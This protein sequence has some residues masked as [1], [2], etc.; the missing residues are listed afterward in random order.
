MTS[1]VQQGAYYSGNDQF[2]DEWSSDIPTWSDTTP[3]VQPGQADDEN[4]QQVTDMENEGDTQPD[5]DQ[6][7]P[8][9]SHAQ[10]DN[11]ETVGQWLRSSALAAS[12]G[13]KEVSH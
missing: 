10:P 1:E 13:S 9:D 12:A 5:G 4:N 6:T 11:V 7:Q 8:A 2:D 3:D